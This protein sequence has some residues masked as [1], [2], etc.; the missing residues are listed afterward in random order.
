M[1]STPDDRRRV[2]LPRSLPDRSR[3]QPYS[4]ADAPYFRSPG[5]F[6]R[7]GGLA[8]ARR[9]G[10]RRARPPRLV[11]PDPARPAVHVD[12]ELPVVPRR[13]PHGSARR[14]RRQPRSS[15]GRY[16]G[17]RGRRRRPERARFDRRARPLEPDGR[18]HETAA[19]ARAA[20]GSRAADARRSA[21]AAR[22]CGR[23]SRRRSSI[24]R[25][26]SGLVDYLA[27]RASSYPAF[28]AT[29]VPSRT[30]PQGALG[31]EFL[32]LLGEVSQNELGTARYAHAKP[33]QI[34]GQ[35]GVEAT[36]DSILSPGFLRAHLRVDSLGRIAGPLEYAHG[37]TPPTLKLTIDARIQRAAEKAIRDG[38]ALAQ[39]NGHGDATSAAAVVMNPRTGGIYALASYPDVQPGGRGERPR[40]PQLALPLDEREP[41]AAEPRDAGPLSD[42]LDVQADRRRGGA[43]AGADHAGDQSALQRLVHARQ[44]H[45][46]QRR[47]GRLLVHVAAD[48]ARRVVRHV[49]LPARQ[50]L[51]PPPAGRPRP[52]DPVVGAHARARAADRR[53]PDRRDG[54]RR[55]DACVAAAHAAPSVVR[56]PDDQP[57]HRPGVPRRHAAPARRRVLGA[58]KRRHGRAPARRR[59]GGQRAVGDAAASSS[60]AA[61]CT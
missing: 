28:K 11:D 13:R 48:G 23:R 8:V 5:F 55:A 38:M 3:P 24:P 60:R 18:R 7:I 34:V 51:L 52:R 45:V 43:D 30:Y 19:H 21:S 27:E 31:A 15:A 61:T 6:V 47:G 36:Y 12:R 20:R 49:V 50:P 46:P 1:A 41:A 35:S 25:P 4:R 39:A 44:L 9:G 14:D 33:G 2:K 42:R 17:S 57:R 10:H 32:G 59:R 37:K 53:R 56:G 58:R 22:C 29:W 26:T 54:R 40:V 16:H